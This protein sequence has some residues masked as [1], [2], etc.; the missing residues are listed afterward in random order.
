VYPE[1][2]LLSVK[3][4]LMNEEACGTAPLNERQPR[5]F[6]AGVFLYLRPLVGIALLVV[7]LKMVP[8]SQV[9]RQLR[10]VNL[11]LLALVFVL[12][13]G[14]V[15]LS[16][17]KLMVL[18]RARSPEV[19][20][21]GV[22]RAYYIGV[23]F[24][25]FLPTGVGGDLM[26]MHELRTERVKTR[27]AFACIVVE[28]AVGLSVVLLIGLVVS[29]FWGGIFSTLEL[30]PLR[31]PLGLGCGVALGVMLCAYAMGLKGLMAVLAPHAGRRL[32]GG[33]FKVVESFSVFRH[34]PGPLGLAFLL[35]CAFYGIMSVSLVI[36]CASIG[37]ELSLVTAGGIIPFRALPEMLPISVGGLGV[38]EGV[39][40]YCLSRVGLTPASAA[41]VALLLRCLSWA[42]SGI[43]GIVYALGR[44][45]HPRSGG[46]D[47]AGEPTRRVP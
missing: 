30:E 11:W 8:L 13:F 19:G 23:F 32:W 4:A 42:H 47:G 46:R 26:K 3:D 17:L 35:S 22:L 43:G 38:R 45:K 28:R 6:W 39:T 20:F 7:L 15:A 24:N 1:V 16:C 44:K 21:A 5:A 37:A 12:V 36:V 34:R 31:W 29:V 18:L 41:S 2:W 27:D 25:N 40:T 9:W 14:D 33:L 10:G